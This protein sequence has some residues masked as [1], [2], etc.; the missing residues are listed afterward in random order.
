MEINPQNKIWHKKIKRLKQYIHNITQTN[1]ITYVQQQNITDTIT[2]V[3]QQN[4]FF[5]HSHMHAH[6]HNHHNKITGTCCNSENHLLFISDERQ[7]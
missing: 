6:T 3:Q 5:I 2:Y 1:T 4:I 7:C